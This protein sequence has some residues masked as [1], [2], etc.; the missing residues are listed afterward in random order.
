MLFYWQKNKDN[1]C[2]VLHARVPILVARVIVENIYLFNHFIHSFIYLDFWLFFYYSFS[3]EY[4]GGFF[5]LFV[6]LLSIIS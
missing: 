6:C 3:F 2:N 4:C 5:S 1:V